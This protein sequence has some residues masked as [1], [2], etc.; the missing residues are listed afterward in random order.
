MRISILLFVLIF[1][2]G[3]CNP[4]EKTPPTGKLEITFAFNKAEDEAVEPSYQLAVWLEDFY[5]NYV[6]TLQLAEYLSLGGYND[7]TIC[8]SWLK[9]TNWDTVSIKYADAITKATPPVGLDTLHFDIDLAKLKPDTYQYCLQ[10][11]IIENYNIQYTGKINIGT[12]PD[13]NIATVFYSP[14]PYNGAENI[15]SSVKAKYSY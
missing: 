8:P 1:L 13:E 2:I 14:K 10:A 6:E 11:H 3:G 4:K 9:H 7:S 12:Q 15:L 5:G